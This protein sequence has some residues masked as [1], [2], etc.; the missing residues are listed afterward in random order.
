VVERARYLGFNAIA[1]TDHDTTDGVTAAMQ[2]AQA[3]PVV[4]PG[5]E[6]SAEAEGLDIHILAYHIR[7]EDPRLQR[8]LRHFQDRRIE[9][10]QQIV[11]R[12]GDLGLPLD[13]EVIYQQAAGAAITRPHVACAMVAAGYVE[14]VREA[15]DRY[16]RTGGPAHIARE[17]LSPQAAIQLIHEAGGVAV[18]AH[19]GVLR[20]Y[21]RWVEQLVPVGLDGVEVNHPINGYQVRQNLRGLARQHDLL[22]T[23]GSDFHTPTD[24][25]GMYLAPQDALRALRTRASRYA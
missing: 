6:I 17:R 12:L 3:F 1:I 10:A 22:M 19:P 9:R 4:I 25:I 18:L 5:I 7:L 15:F 13:W 21:L 8:E 2:A 23:G 14:S 11:A 24:P 20:E 16:L